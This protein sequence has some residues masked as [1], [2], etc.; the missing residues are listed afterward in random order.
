[1]AS[2]KPQRQT[3]PR[4]SKWKQSDF[5]SSSRKPGSN[6]LGGEHVFLILLALRILNALTIK[7]FFQPDE[8]YQ[9]LEPAWRLAYGADRGAWITWVSAQFFRSVHFEPGLTRTAGMAEP[10]EILATSDS[11]CW[12]L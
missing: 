6:W 2:S 10:I 11:V 5:T 7:T 12:R 8:Y 1:M 3:K 4:P 9:S